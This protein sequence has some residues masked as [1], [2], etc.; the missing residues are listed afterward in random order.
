MPRNIRLSSP[1]ASYLLRLGDGLVI[2]ISGLLALNIRKVLNLPI[3]FPV[4]LSGYYSLIAVGAL[5][6]ATLSGSVYRSWRGAVMPAMLAKITGKWLLVVG[7]ILLWLFIFKTSSEFSRVWFGVWVALGVCF[8]WL[9]RL[10][11]YFFLR[12]LRLRGFNLR[13]VALIGSGSATKNLE[14]RISSSGWSGYSLVKVIPH[15][16]KVELEKLTRSSVDEIWLALPLGNETA[17]RDTLHALRHSTA[18]IRFAPDLFTLRLVNHGVSDILGIPMYDLST[19]PITGINQFFKWCED[20]IL[21]ILILLIIS[22]IMLLLAIGVK[23]S[24]PGPVFYRQERV[25]LSGATFNMLKFRS[26]PVDTEKSGVQWGGSAVKAT[27]SFGQFIR[28]T[29][30]DELP[31]FLNV[32]KGDMSIVGPRPERPMFVEQFKEEIPDYMKKHLVKAGITGWAQVNG[33]RGDTD[34]ATRIEYDLYY[35]ENW[36]IGFDLKII[37]LTI[38]KGFVS[39]HAY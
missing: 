6:F 5:L 11:L 34:L 32:L 35:I 17:I 26:M 31:Q 36:S 21:S 22:P 15:T 2:F 13:H 10:G 16:D 25:G 12:I 9:E 30:L 28:K 39:K 33:W 3:E 29:S 20:K 37:L 27:T 19:S 24:S 1:I 14:Q 18:S 38:F 7:I 8:L 4:N 23:L